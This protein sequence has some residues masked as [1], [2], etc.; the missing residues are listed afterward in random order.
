[1]HADVACLLCSIP[2]GSV[3]MVVPV[4]QATIIAAP[5]L[6][7]DQIRQGVRAA[8]MWLAARGGTEERPANAVRPGSPP[9]GRPPER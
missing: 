8:R 5:I 2:P 1:M 6:L 4:A 7:R 9:K 3:D